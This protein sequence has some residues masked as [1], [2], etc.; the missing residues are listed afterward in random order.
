M[1]GV[2]FLSI[3][4][5][6]KILNNSLENI[7]NGIVSSSL[8]KILQIIG[9]IIGKTREEQKIAIAN[10]IEVSQPSVYGWNILNTNLRRSNLPIKFYKMSGWKFPVL[11]YDGIVLNLISED[12]FRYARKTIFKE[13]CVP[14]HTACLAMK[15]NEGVPVKQYSLFPEYD[16]DLS[17]KVREKTNNILK[18]LPIVQENIIAFVSIVIKKVD[19][20][21]ASAKLMAFDVNMDYVGNGIDITPYFG[22]EMPIVVENVEQSVPDVNCSPNDN[23]RLNEKS[24]RRMADKK[25]NKLKSITAEDIS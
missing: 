4:V 11:V 21:I 2:T 20:E 3:K 1:K 23:L 25:K 6:T 19:G 14:H 16:E 15:F 7:I 22:V 13:N 12:R 17:E 5:S 18:Q 9:S 8:H 10:L 24:L